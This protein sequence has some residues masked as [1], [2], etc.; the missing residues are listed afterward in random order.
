MSKTRRI[1]ELSEAEKQRFW[2][3][4]EKRQDGCWV[5]TG[6]TVT[7]NSAG[8][9]FYGYVHIGSH[10]YLAHRVSWSMFHGQ[11]PEG[12]VADHQCHNPLCVNPAHLHVVTHQE[13]DENRLGPSSSKSNRPR[14]GFRGVTWDESR[15]KWRVSVK[16][17]GRSYNGGRYADANEANRAAI[18]LRN[19]LMTNNLLDR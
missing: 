11:I 18:A 16:H 7:T 4:V 12:M 13:N 14:S 17:S 8:K 10:M 15:H 3:K 9:L 19:K 1:P 5:W 2:D 6:R